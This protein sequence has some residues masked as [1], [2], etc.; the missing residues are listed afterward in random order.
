MTLNNKKD[1]V[2]IKKRNE[3]IKT[4]ELVQNLNR[5]SWWLAECL[6]VKGNTQYAWLSQWTTC[7]TLFTTPRG[8]RANEPSAVPCSHLTHCTTL[9]NARFSCN[10]RGKAT[11]VRQNAPSQTEIKQLDTPL[12]FWAW[13]L[14]KETLRPAPHI[15]S[16]QLQTLT[17]LLSY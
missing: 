8:E 6:F 2:S 12:S 3:Q 13:A 17:S 15:A 1:K 7:V 5:S 10:T 9:V 4:V 14:I 16:S 11:N